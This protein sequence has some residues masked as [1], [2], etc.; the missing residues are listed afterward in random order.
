[1]MKMKKATVFFFLCIL[2]SCRGEDPVPDKTA[3]TAPPSVAPHE[4][5]LVRGNGWVTGIPGIARNAFPAL[6]GVYRLE[7]LEF[8]EPEEGAGTEKAVFWVYAGREPVVFSG[9]WQRRPETGNNGVLQRLRGKDLLAATV[10]EAGPVQ[11]SW[12]VIFEFPGGILDTGLESAGLGRLIEAWSSRF[13]YF[14]SFIKTPGD[15]S[16]PAVVFF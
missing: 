10:I 15:A 8:Q 13:L 14:V 3:R 9:D 5:V 1:M 11:G 12:T 6:L 16:L 7:G 2:F 4:A